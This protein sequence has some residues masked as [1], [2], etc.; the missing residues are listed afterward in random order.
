MLPTIVTSRPSRIQTVPRPIT[1]RQCQP[2]QGRR[3]RRD[4]I[5]VSIVDVSAGASM[6]CGSTLLA[7]GA[8]Q[9]TAATPIGEAKAE[10]RGAAGPGDGG[11]PRRGGQRPRPAPVADAGYGA[12]DPPPG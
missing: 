2:A 1:I 3:S 10:A 11:V 8:T 9:P 4:G 5:R 6:R 12:Q 7:R